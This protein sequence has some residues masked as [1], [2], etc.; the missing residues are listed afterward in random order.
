MRR[1][2]VNASPDPQTREPPLTLRLSQPASHVY[3]DL[4]TCLARDLSLYHM[5]RGRY[6]SHGQKIS[7][8]CH[9]YLYSPGEKQG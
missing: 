5:K 3:L 7:Q 9:L 4:V 1:N 2:F 6:T 8:K